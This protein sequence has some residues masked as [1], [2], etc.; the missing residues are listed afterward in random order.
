MR[1]W[2]QGYLHRG[3]GFGDEDIIMTK[4]TI[5]QGLA[6]WLISSAAIVMLSLAALYVG[7]IHVSQ[8]Y[9]QFG[10]SL[11]S[12]TAIIMS[13]SIESYFLS[14]LVITFLYWSGAAVLGK[15]NIINILSANI[16][17]SLAGAMFGGMM[18]NYI[19]QWVPAEMTNCIDL[20][21][22]VTVTHQRC[23]VNNFWFHALDYG[24]LAVIFASLAVRIVQS[25]KMAKVES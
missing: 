24:S 17:L 19:F 4:R 5:L 22:D 12:H 16:L 2:R 20:R 8:Y 18:L 13:S 11:A 15:G 1:A 9:G 10:G 7:S 25:R 21:T 6:G 3:R 14:L 23:F